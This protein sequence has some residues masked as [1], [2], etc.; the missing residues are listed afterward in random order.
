MG[1]ILEWNLSHNGTPSKN[2]PLPFKSEDRIDGK[3]MKVSADDTV[4]LVILAPQGHSYGGLNWNL[5]VLGR[6]SPDRA[7]QEINN[8][9]RQFPVSNSPASHIK[10]GNPWADVIQMLWA[11]NEFQYID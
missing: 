6:E 5:R 1:D 11:S 3:W 7:P 10:P 8:F 9:N 4:D 2:R